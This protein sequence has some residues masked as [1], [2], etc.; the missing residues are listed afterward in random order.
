MP[1]LPGMKRKGTRS[2]KGD[3]NRSKLMT[4]RFKYESLKQFRQ[5]VYKCKVVYWLILPEPV[6]FIFSKIEAVVLSGIFI[7]FAYSRRV[8][9]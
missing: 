4:K 1:T 5:E 8:V 2:F 6:L 7:S 3:K 9:W